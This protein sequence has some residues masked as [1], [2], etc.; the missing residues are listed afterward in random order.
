MEAALAALPLPVC[1]LRAGGVID[2][3]NPGA[4]VLAGWGLQGG[5]V[6][7]HVERGA[8]CRAGQVDATTLA[9]LL[10]SA[11]R[12]I[13][14]VCATWFDD[15]GEVHTCVL[16]FMA[17]AADSPFR[18]AWPQ[19]AVLL[20][21]D[22][23]DAGTHA[24][25]RLEAITSRFGLTPAESRLLQLLHRGRTPAEAAEQL[26]VCMSTVRTQVAALLGK[27]GARR[28]VDLMRLLVG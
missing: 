11:A 28:Q 17:L 23:F 14:R 6:L 1:V 27:T 5:G 26:G 19:A 9:S 8:L 25:A 13:N 4:Q 12:G 2:H 24:A 7:L 21:I 10:A 18:T 15:E 16:R 22:T 20:L 3:L